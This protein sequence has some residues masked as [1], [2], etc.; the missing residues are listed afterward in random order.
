[1]RKTV[2]SLL[3]LFWSGCATVRADEPMNTC[4]GLSGTWARPAQ[5]SYDV[6]RRYDAIERS[7]RF[8]DNID[9]SQATCPSGR[10]G[11]VVG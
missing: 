6:S 9:L 3:L 1:M 4:D 5:G 2:L 10:T 8:V 7:V 11:R